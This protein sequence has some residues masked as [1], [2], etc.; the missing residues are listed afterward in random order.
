MTRDELLERLQ[1]LNG[2]LATKDIHATMYVYGGF[3]MCFA[4]ELRDTTSDIDCIH[5]NYEVDKIARDM[6]NEYGLQKDWLNTAVKDFVHTDMCK[7]SF[8]STVKLSNLDI[9]IP[10]PEQMLAMKLFSA[11]F[12]SNDLRD[13]TQLAMGLHITT[14]TQLHEVLKKYFKDKSIRE[15]NKYQKNCIG[16][17]I[18]VV[19]DEIESLSTSGDG[20]Q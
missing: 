6:A 20:V 10:S 2:R 13:A 7:Q 3:V 17:F 16:R 11:R 1:E 15:K 4:Y 18:E 12:E 14:K 9:V 19:A 5:D 8:V